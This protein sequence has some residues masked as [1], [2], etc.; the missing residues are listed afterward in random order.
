MLTG[1]IGV[2]FNWRGKLIVQVL[3]RVPDVPGFPGGEHWEDATV[4]TL[5]R[6]MEIAKEKDIPPFNAQ[7]TAALQ[8]SSQ[9][10]P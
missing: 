9:E 6:S 10:K 4:M 2:R 5:V 1:R 7:H 8:P 3:R